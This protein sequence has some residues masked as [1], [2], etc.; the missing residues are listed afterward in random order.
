MSDALSDERS[1]LSFTMYNVQY[2]CILRAILRYSFT[3]LVQPNLPH[4][5]THTH[6][7]EGLH[8]GDIW[9]NIWTNIRRAILERNFDI[10]SGRAAC[11]ARS[12]TWNSGYQLSICSRTKE[13]HRNPWSSWPVTGPSRCKLT[14]NLT[15]IP[16][17][18]S[19]RTAHKTPLQMY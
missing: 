6:T 5:H 7:P 8:Y 11:E 9:T 18:G 14:K 15:R 17:I 10:T 12:A 19:A 16:F 13:N 3:N 2:I 1:G 4:T